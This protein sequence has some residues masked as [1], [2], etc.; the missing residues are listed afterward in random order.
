[1]FFTALT[2]FVLAG[3]ATNHKDFNYPDSP[4]FPIICWVAFLLVALV[5]SF[6]LL[7]LHD[8]NRINKVAAAQAENELARLAVGESWTQFFFPTS[9]NSKS[10]TGTRRWDPIWIWQTI[11]LLLFALLASLFATRL[12]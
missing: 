6:Y 5:S 1:M 7:R 2:F 3:A 8:A 12:R 11:F 4:W 9:G 10:S